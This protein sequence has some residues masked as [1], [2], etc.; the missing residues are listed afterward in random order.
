MEALQTL[1]P[2]DSSWQNRTPA[3]IVFQLIRYRPLRDAAQI[4]APVLLV[5][6]EDDNLIPIRG[7]EAASRRIPNC[8]Y[9][10]LSGTGHFEPYIG[11][12]FERVVERE[13]E[14]LCKHLRV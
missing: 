12:V 5:A 1:I 6:A 13:A 9:V 7:V 3:R 4:R 14:F 2:P 10:C 11:E 8:E